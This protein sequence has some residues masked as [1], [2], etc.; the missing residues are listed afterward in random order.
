MLDS[1]SLYKNCQPLES[2][3]DDERYNGPQNLDRLICYTGERKRG[4]PSGEFE[5][6][7]S[8]IV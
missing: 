2:L 3:D 4:G 7:A 1:F 8:A 6:A 5:E